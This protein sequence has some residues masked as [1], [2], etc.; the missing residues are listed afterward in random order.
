MLLS[1][2]V[3]YIYFLLKIMVDIIARTMDS[4]FQYIYT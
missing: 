1:V 4:N 3:G 2:V